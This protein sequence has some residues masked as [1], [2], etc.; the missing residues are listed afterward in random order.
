MSAEHYLGLISG[1]SLDGIDVVLANFEQCQPQ[2]M[3]AL[4]HPMPPAFQHQLMQLCESATTSLEQL[5]QADAR[6]ALLQ[7]E[8]VRCLLKETGVSADC[9]RALGSHG[10][11]LRHRPDTDPPLSLQIGDPNILAEE[12]GIDVIADFRRRDLAAGGQAAPLVPAFHAAHFR[13]REVDRL[14]VNIGGITNI[15]LLPADANG[16]V[17]GFDTGPGNLLMDLQARRHLG[18][19]FDRDGAWAAQGRVHPELLA[20]L[21]ADDYFKLEA[22]K[23]TGRELFNAH[24]LDERLKSLEQDPRPADVQATLMEFT[25]ESLAREVERLSPRPQAL[26]VCGGG[27]H[28]THLMKRLQERLDGQCSVGTTLELGMSPDWVEGMTFAWLA[29]QFLAQKPGNLPSVTGARGYRILGGHY[30]A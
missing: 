30:P 28:N 4:T 9:V 14:I 29:R 19:P 18:A 12:T 23:S 27:A 5:G 7:S 8:A 11:T 24:W 22:P 10:Q 13:S 26:Y 25:I 3:A 21:L 20:C 1:T 16:P 17:T 6:F 2:L 15:S